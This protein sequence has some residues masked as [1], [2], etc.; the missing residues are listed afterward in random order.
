MDMKLKVILTVLLVLKISQVYTQ[1]AGDWAGDDYYDGD[2]SAGDQTT[3]PTCGGNCDTSKNCP[4]CP[5]GSNANNQDPT[6][7]CKKFN[8]WNQACCV[9]IV[10]HESNGNAN[11]MNWNK[12][13]LRKDP[14]SESSLMWPYS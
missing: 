11:A 6:E 5:C 10:T 12:P 9:C 13:R 14:P 4:S 3:D 7:W 8:K 2:D 1:G